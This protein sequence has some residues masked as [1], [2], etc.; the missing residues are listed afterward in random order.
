MGLIL[1][2]SKT[3]ALTRIKMEWMEVVNMSKAETFVQNFDL[4][5]YRKVF[6]KSHTIQLK[7]EHKMNENKDL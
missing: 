2:K 7:S 3:D 6:E 5:E 1:E 4:I